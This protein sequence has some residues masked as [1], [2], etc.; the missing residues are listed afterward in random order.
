MQRATVICVGSSH[1]HSIV[2]AARVANVELA[3]INLKHTAALVDD[4]T[5]PALQPTI[6]EQLAGKTVI[7]LVGGNSHNQIG[8]VRHPRPFD[9]VLPSEPELPSDDGELIPSAALET[10]LHKRMSG[11][12]SIMKLLRRQALG[13]MYHFESPPP[14]ADDDYIRASIDPYF[15]RRGV[16]DLGIVSPRL[17]YK[18]WR[19]HSELVRR[20][21]LALKI[22]FVACP[23]EAMAGGF[24]RAELCANATHANERYGAMLL[25]QIEAL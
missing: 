18:L 20:A 23:P 10:V 25:S 6:V 3:A 5:A 14:V 19:L 17:R 7:S 12:L 8:L 13:R 24:L 22:E 16:A 4:S 9:F 1:I 11:A 21:C 2:A 15:Q